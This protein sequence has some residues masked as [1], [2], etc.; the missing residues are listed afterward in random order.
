MKNVWCHTDPLTKCA[1]AL[2]TATGSKLWDVPSS[3]N[4]LSESL[5][6]QPHCHYH[7]LQD[8]VRITAETP[9]KLDGTWLS[10]RCEVRPGPEFLTRSYTFHP[11][12]H[13]QA[14][15]HYYSDS[16]CQDPAYSLLIQGKLRLRQA[17][18]ITR[19]ATEAHHH[20]T[21][22]AIVIHSLAAKQSLVSKLPPSCVG[23]TLGRVVTG[24]PHDLHNTRA[25]RACLAAMGF[26]MMEMDVVRVEIQH[27][28]HGGEIQQLFLG[29]I[30]TDWTQRTHYRP[31]GY[32]QPLQSAMH[33]IH[34]CPV[35]ALVY[36]AT[37][38]H[39]PV[40]P[41][42]PQ[43]PVSLARRW[44]SQQCET[45]PTVLF[46]T[47]EFNFNPDQHSW[48]GIYRHYS[49]PVCSQK[50]FTLR[51][52]GHYAQGNPSAK[53]PGATE[54]VFKVTE[55]RVT[56]EDEPTAKLLNG[57]KTGKCGHAGAWEVGVEQ[58]LSPTHGCTVLGIK[59]PHKEYELFKVELDHRR[60]LLL[61]VGERP[62]DGSSP[63][64][65]S[66]R[67]TSFQPPLMLCNGGETQ[68]YGHNSPGFNSK[69]VQ[70]DTN[71]TG[72][73]IQLQLVVLGS[74]LCSWIWLF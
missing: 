50:T 3:S 35:C 27:H 44:V 68:P 52:S 69:Q 8:G 62:T 38:Q 20:L 54:F 71:G 30:Q 64:R 10:T 24:E 15:Q 36:R 29:D 58:D 25:G 55:V 56:A 61:Y 45:R 73:L 19:G 42:R 72:R 41:H 53:V 7:H 16:G 33:H 40:L 5:Q 28:N 34:P 14:L 2:M 57:T 39:P 26:S 43:A 46:L 13:F 66:R 60:H 21:K 9:P 49:D 22:V 74:A 18:W 12:R 70:T 6:W 59:L 17:S 32:Q 67:A 11:T 37:E 4:N 63:D 51:A 1:V 23:P 48:E 47:R 31:T 65:P